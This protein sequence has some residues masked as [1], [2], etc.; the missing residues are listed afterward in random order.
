MQGGA[1]KLEVSRREMLG[2][3]RANL[4]AVID[5]TPPEPNFILRSS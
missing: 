1:L 3:K 5:N 4:V 2:I